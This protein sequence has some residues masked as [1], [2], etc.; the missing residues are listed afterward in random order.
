VPSPHSRGRGS[1]AA[2]PEDK[3]NDTLDVWRRKKLARNED[4]E[5]NSLKD[6]A[7]LVQ[8]E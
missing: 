6:G 5:V 2:G 3:E 8:R 1:D 4:G 7:D